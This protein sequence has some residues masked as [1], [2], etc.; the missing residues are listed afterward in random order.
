MKRR[1]VWPAGYRKPNEPSQATMDIVYASHNTVKNMAPLDD[2][3]SDAQTLK[4][5]AVRR[6]SR[7]ML[8]RAKYRRQHV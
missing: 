3:M 2:I 8:D 6:L 5:A 7:T 4:C 1:R